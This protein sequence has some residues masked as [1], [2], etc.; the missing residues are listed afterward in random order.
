MGVDNAVIADGDPVGISAEVLKDTLEAIEGRLAIDDPLLMIEL[1]PESL[2][3]PR[4]L[5]VPDTVGEYKSIR[6]EASFEKVKEL[7][8]EQRRYHPNRDEKP[9]SA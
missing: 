8:F 1:A 3:V 9:F 2:K 7:S 4:L 6:L 5:E